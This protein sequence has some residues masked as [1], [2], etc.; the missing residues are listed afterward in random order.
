MNHCA[1]I[2]RIVLISIASNACWA[3]TPRAPV[4]DTLPATADIE[5]RSGAATLSGTLV[6]PS[7]MWA[8]VVLVHG[9]GQEPRNVSLAHTL[10]DN[11]IATLTYDKRGVAKS[12]G[13][14][15]GPEVGTN[16]VDSA[17]LNLLA[18][19]AAAAANALRRQL[20]RRSIP[21]G[22]LGASQAGWIIP[23]A[24][25]RSPEVEFMVLWSGPLVTAREQLRFQFLTEGKEDFW[26]AHGEAEVREHI[27]SDP[28]RFQF[29]DTDPRV[30]LQTL[31]IPGLWL[32]G[33]RDVNV[34]A[35]LSIERLGVL[36]SLGKRF[37]YQLF[38]GSGH[39]L[40]AA[41]AVPATLDWLTNTVIQ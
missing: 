12:G 15:A 4:A 2:T 27:R 1:R 8:A 11:G 36:I 19:D 30:P 29:E 33:E 39:A 38:P 34:P 35:H 21:V 40:R 26:D 6:R 7:S 14:Y 18:D 5:F 25:A 31:S 10:A 24:A 22:L 37:D 9:S 13:V 41:D 17:N 3:Q 20:P 28:D 16:N 23:L 32:Y